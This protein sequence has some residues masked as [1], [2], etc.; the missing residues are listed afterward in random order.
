[1]RTNSTKADAGIAHSSFDAWLKMGLALMTSFPL[2]CYA[3]E[4]CNPGVV[5]AG[6]KPPAAEQK[7]TPPTPPN[8]ASI[9]MK[10]AVA[11]GVTTGFALASGAV[12]MNPLVSPT[13]LGLVA[14][15]G[16]KIAV[17]KYADHMPEDQKR[18]VMKTS[19]AV[20]GGAAVNNLMVL[21][22]APPPFPIIAGLAMAYIGWRHM[23]RGYEE[24]DRLVAAQAKPAPAALTACNAEPEPA[25]GQTV[26]AAVAE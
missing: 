22:A 13:P 23:T 25:P 17:V 18:T 6:E 16:V 10:A 12:E 1:M 26:A 4:G 24:Y 20:W 19:S 7:V 5:V 3:A 11:D 8:G 9:A 21:V 15:T 14:L 2:M